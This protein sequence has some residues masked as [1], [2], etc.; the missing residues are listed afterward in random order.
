MKPGNLLF[1]AF[2]FIFNIPISYGKSTA[3]MKHIMASKYNN[4]IIV[5]QISNI[6]SDFYNAFNI[7]KTLLCYVLLMDHLKMF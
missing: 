4:N 6:F 7:K 2:R 1:H 5:V 3:L